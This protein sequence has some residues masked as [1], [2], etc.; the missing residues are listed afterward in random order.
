MPPRT[1]FVPG[2]EFGSSKFRTL[3]RSRGAAA[4]SALETCRTG[5]MDPIR[6][7]V[8]SYR[9][10][11]GIAASIQRLYPDAFTDPLG[12]SKDGMG[13]M[14][15]NKLIIE[16]FTRAIKDAAEIARGVAEFAYPKYQRI[17]HVGDAPT[18]QVNQKVVVT[19]N[20]GGDQAPKPVSG[21]TIENEEPV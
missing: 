19:L 1:A 8:D 15:E 20:I 16:T 14:V 10:M 3:T 12:Q 13:R 7:Q 17:H 6:V 18:G 11:Y 2:H 9:T 5:G 4:T 21:V